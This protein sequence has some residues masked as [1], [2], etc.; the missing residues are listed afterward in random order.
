[1]YTYCILILNNNDEVKPV[2]VG[3]HMITHKYVVYK[4][5]IGPI[6]DENLVKL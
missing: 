1:M 2:K 5:S 6:I 3:H 4:N